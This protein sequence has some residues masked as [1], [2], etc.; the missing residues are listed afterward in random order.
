MT[1]TDSPTGWAPPTPPP[2]RLLRRSTTDRIGAGVAGGLAEYFRVDP[3][4]FRVLFAT[5]AFFGGAGIIAYLLAWAAIPE[6]GTQHAPIDRVVAGLRH[7]RFP[8]TVLLVIGAL[9]L[10]ALAFSW[11]APG[12]F[13][14]VFLLVIVMVVLF[15]RRDPAA[16][17]SRPVPPP[18][19]PTAAP[20]TAPTGAGDAATVS[21]DKPAAP[22]AEGPTWPADTR[23]WLQESRAAS[24]ERRR[25]A[26]PVRWTTLGVLAAT[27]TVLALVD[28]ASGIAIPVYAWATLGIVGLGLIAGLA[29]RRTPWSVSVLLI[30]AVFALLAFGGTHASLH[31]GFGQRNWTPTRASAIDDEYRLAFGQGVLDLRSVGTLD[32]PHDIDVVMAAGQVQVLLPPTMNA[33]VDANVRLGAVTVDGDTIDRSGNVGFGPNRDNRGFGVEHTVLPPAGATGPEVH[34]H[35]RLADGEVRVDHR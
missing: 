19:E 4:L 7:R 15:G 16:R 21:L 24:R 1:T 13:F 12:P 33:T 29:L 14:P 11:W 35:V 32:G 22:P 23:Q 9:L 8:A 34:I 25:R 5:S 30:P 27:V 31:D 3:V 26:A 17:S 18:V 6:E 20:W 10:W 2:A 28:A